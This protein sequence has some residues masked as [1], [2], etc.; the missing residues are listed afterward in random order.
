[1]FPIYLLKEKFFA[2][3]LVSELYV[4]AFSA[5]HCVTWNVPFYIE[6]SGKLIVLSDVA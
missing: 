4:G 1:M 2:N 5:H 3:V 6:S